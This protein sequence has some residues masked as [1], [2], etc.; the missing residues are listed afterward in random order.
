M[1]TP[2]PFFAAIL[3]LACFPVLAAPV[4]LLDE[5]FT[6]GTGPSNTA[7]A[8]W[9]QTDTAAF[10]AYGNG[11]FG[12]RGIS[13]GA[14][15]VAPLGGL[16]VLASASTNKITISIAL[17]A[18]LDHSVDGV[19][20]FLA[21]QRIESGSGGFEGALEIVNVTDSRTI[22]SKSGVS[23]PN[24]TMT[25]NSVAIDFV[26][27]DAGDTLEL[28]FYESAGNSARG[29]ELADLKLDVSTVTVGE[30][31]LSNAAVNTITT[32][33]A[34][35]SADLANSAADVTLFWSA[36]D[37]G[38]NL[39][40]W[41][42]NGSSSALGNQPVGTVSGSLTGL[43]GD[44]AYVCRFYAVNTTPDPDQEAWSAPVSFTTPLTGKAVTDLTA[45]A[46][47]AYEVDL[48]WTDNF[49]TETSYVIQRSPAGAGTWTTVATRPANTQFHTDVHTG[50]L[51]G[52][53]Y[54]YR[55]IAAN[56][57]GD[58]DPSNT[59][60][61]TTTAA[62]PI[63]T[64]L[65][66]NFDGSVS[67]TT[68]TL[69]PG[70]S[71]VTGTFKANG[72]PV[73]GAG[74]ASINSGAGGGTAGFDFNPASLGDL[75]T[76]NW[77]VE[78][79][80]TFQSFAGTLP[81]AISVQ[82]VDFRVNN[83][84]TALETVYYNEVVDTRQTT[85]LPALGTQVHLAM[86][87]DASTGTLNG[88]VDGNPIGPVSAGAFEA[89]DPSNV[90]FG[91][92]GRVGF[93]NRGIDGILDA[94]SFRSGT[95]A[96]N[97]AT[98]F[99]ILPTGSTYSSWI[100]GFGIAPGSLGF[101]AD[102]DADGLSNG[103]EA[104]FGTNPNSPGTGI[105]NVTTTGT[106]TTFTHPQADPP[107][108]DIIAS[109][110]WSTDLVNWFDGDGVDGPGGGLTVNIPAVTPVAGVSTVTATASQSVQKMFVRIRTRNE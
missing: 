9:S 33:G 86:V 78:A 63:S 53:A 89:P 98:D 65:L 4:T 16:E 91:Y 79:L 94:V 102:P 5:E 107:I 6:S 39:V 109:Y 48:S 84:K 27:A 83:A 52:T 8:T 21:G 17:P 18:T 93:D 55:V 59:S 54:D 61:A 97:P 67:G 56:A 41:Q 24:F 19:F 30:P 58:S 72:S 49:D 110:E 38:T 11:G 60:S 101:N 100:T 106:V 22:R 29:L 44:T 13:G 14:T 95:T 36:T 68:Y 76:Q 99:V 73:L 34:N 23:R 32:T 77:V 15:P 45:T 70:E 46:F 66:V 12:A 80:V 26:A 103:V 20:T 3:A 51:P 1:K 87:W 25:A 57:G 28:R 92:F 40:D 64:N 42:T 85:S 88:Y 74:L 50:L 69:A 31:T 104:F 35:A 47:S 82:D 108:D 2:Y 10:E 81:T 7:T 105:S 90:S 71:D 96:V 37:Y 75:R 43:T 62:S